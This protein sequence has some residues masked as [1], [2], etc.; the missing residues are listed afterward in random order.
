MSLPILYSLTSKGQV[1][2]WQIEVKDARFRTHEGIESG[3]I[4]V[5][6]WTTCK[7][8]NLGRANETSGPE[9]ADKEAKSRHQKKLDSGYYE[10]SC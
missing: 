1:Q 5:S 9:Q 2:T 7:G 8:K 6:D 10:D 3:V 4:T